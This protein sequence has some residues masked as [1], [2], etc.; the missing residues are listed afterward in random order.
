MAPK[1]GLPGSVDIINQKTGDVVM[2]YP[3]N[4]DRVVNLSQTSVV[5]VNASPASVNFYEREGNDL[6][7]HMKDGS[8]VRYQK[9]FFL[10]ENGLHSQL[11]F[12]DNLGAH[13]AVFPF[14][15]EAGPLTAEAIVP[16][17]ADV[18]VGSLIGAG[19]ISAL[20]VLGGLAAVGGI[21][22]V[23]AASSGGGGGGSDNDNNNGGTTPPDGG[24]TPPGDGGSPTPPD[25]GG[26]TPPDGGGT[27]PPDG[28]GTTPPDGGGTAPPVEST[29]TVDPLTE[30]NLLNLETV[31]LS[32]VLSGSTQAEN[33]GCLIT[34]MWGDSVWTT[35]VNDDGSWAL[36]FP[37]E[38]LQSFSQGQS[39]LRVRLVDNRGTALE[40]AMPVIVDTIPPALDPVEFVPNCIF[41]S[42]QLNGD[43]ILR[44]YSEAA[45]EGS[46]VLI[47]LNGKTYSAIVDSSGNW[48]TSIPLA[49]LQALGDG[50]S[51]TITYEIT[52]L[53]GNVSTSSSDFTVNLTA[54]I[55]TVNPL[56]GDDVL[57]SAEIQLDQVLS[58]TTENIAAGQTVTITLGGQTWYAVVQGDGS[59]SVTLPSGDLLA[60]G[61]GPGT[62]TVR[63]VDKNNQTI[64]SNHPI[65]VDTA[66]SGIAIAIVSTDD[67]LNAAEATQPLEVR[68]VTTVVGPSV[69]VL[70]EFNGKT[71]TAVVDNAGYWSAVIPVADLAELKD[72]PRQITATVTLG[73]QSASDEHILHVAINHVPQ[74]TLSTPFVDGILSAAER[75]IP[76]AISGNTGISGAGQKVSVLLGGKTYTAT[77]DSDGNWAITVPPADLQTLPQGSLSMIVNASDAAGNNATLPAS[78]IVDTLAPDLAVLP[79]SGDGRLGVEDLNIAQ[80]LSG[81]SSMNE[82]GQPITVVLNNKTYTTTV[83]SDGN[84]SITLPSADLQQL[85]NGANV[86]TVT[87]TDA[88]GNARVVEQTINVKTT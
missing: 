5:R 85:V 84:W 26:T 60:L 6:I 10:D 17:M 50:D 65:T 40:A 52:D 14:A 44:G 32:Q 79:I 66:Q 8:T 28:G 35:T 48:Q 51:Y 2:E 37:P 38:V 42:S 22:G 34:V 31:S 70:V 81:I 45:D 15:S 87:L 7:V 41:D 19:G 78:A 46:T 12:E 63:V 1:N 24:T 23:A 43:K 33:A 61:N 53:A 13:Q 16:A 69:S 62:I 75:D 9:F 21:V 71:Y 83:G 77:V 36:V 11:V 59:W 86:A 54:P 49:D 74:P 39:L 27:T 56:T 29:L 73:T 82:A 68:G 80:A 76:Q 72:G 67:Y 58:G 25:G 47:T 88:A 55:I 57:N 18:A 64:T 4:A 3:Q 30:D 20:A